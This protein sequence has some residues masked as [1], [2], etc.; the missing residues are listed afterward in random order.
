[1]NEEEYSPQS[2]DEEPFD[3]CDSKIPDDLTIDSKLMADHFL[4]NEIASGWIIICR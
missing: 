4:M 1:M 3:D 2:K